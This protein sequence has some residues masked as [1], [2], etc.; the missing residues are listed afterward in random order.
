MIGVVFA[1]M[2][3]FSFSLS[4]V[5]VRRAVA[6][7]PVAYGAIAT[8][9]MGVPLFFIATLVA[10]QF[11]NAGDISAKGYALLAC[12]G[13]IHYVVGRFF[14][15]AAIGAI[16]ATRSAPIQALNLPYS[17]FVA[18]I[19]LDEGVNAG[20]TAAIV[21][22]MIGPL[23]MIER[24]RRRPPVITDPVIVEGAPA[25]T[26]EKPEAALRTTEGYLFALVAAVCYGS[27][28]VLIRSA[29]EGESGVSI[30]GGLVS[31][32]AAATVL[33]ASLALPN[34]RHLAG[35]LAP[36]NFRAFAAPGIAVFLAQ[37][38]R[39]LALSEAP[40]AVVTTLLRL[41]SVFTLGLSFFFN[42]HL[43]HIT[44]RVVAGI[45]MSVIGAILLVA[46]QE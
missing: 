30:L 29:L 43:E 17:V 23:L 21:L 27:S 11:A 13:A 32:I 31:Y 3:A 10:G 18:Y 2:S 41:G 37:M 5:S 36:A 16:G 22:I 9:L 38:F 34:R 26:V 4:D 12:A 20:M 8:V 33:L 44:W 28:P 6:K 46:F 40:V 1:L 15:Y 14:N 25:L 19:F 24:P 45:G 39:F 35:A 7:A 42:K